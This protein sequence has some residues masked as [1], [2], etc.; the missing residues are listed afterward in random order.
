MVI[1]KMINWLRKKLIGNTMSPEVADKAY[2]ASYDAYANIGLV[3]SDMENIPL[4]ERDDNWLL[5]LS[6][7]AKA[8]AELY[9]SLVAILED[10]SAGRAELKRLNPE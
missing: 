9:Y 8:E 7:L 6:R 10:T 4:G 2:E 3:L 5:T 1:L